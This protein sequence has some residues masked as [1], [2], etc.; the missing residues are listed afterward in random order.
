[1][2][3]THAISTERLVNVLQSIA[4]KQQTGCL[5]VAREQGQTQATEKGN[6]FFERGDTVFALTTQASGETALHS[7]LNWKQVS[8]TF[9]EGIRYLPEESSSGFGITRRITRDL[10]DDSDDAS[11]RPSRLSQTLNMRRLSAIKAAEG[12]QTPPIGIP[13]LPKTLPVS[14]PIEMVETHLLPAINL[15]DIPTP[16]PP[17]MPLHEPPAVQCMIFSQCDTEKREQ[18]MPGEQKS[19]RTSHDSSVVPMGVT[20]IFRALPLATAPSALSRMERRERVVLLLLNGKRTLRDVAILVHQSE[21][22]VARTVVRLL[23]QGCIEHLGAN[24]Y[25]IG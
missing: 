25:E 13:A 23:K 11:P 12:R 24:E 6:I 18:I 2:T 15:A 7:M 8:Y 10:S 19:E 20:S 1:M 3:I 14:S 17:E 5:T 4:L 9:I 16:L 21:V 22:D